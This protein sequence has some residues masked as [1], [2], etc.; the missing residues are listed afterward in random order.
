MFVGHIGAALALKTRAKDTSLASLFFAAMFIDFVW[1]L[2]ILLGIE[3][4]EIAPGYTAATPLKF[5]S[6]PY[7]HSLALVVLYALVIGVAYFLIKK[8]RAAAI[9]MAAAVLSHWLL[10]WVSHIPDL[11]LFPGSDIYAGLGLWKNLAASIEVEAAL[12]V[13]GI[14]LYARDFKFATKGRMCGFIALVIVLIA[15][16]LMPQFAPPPPSAKAVAVGALFM[17]L[18]VP[19][20]Y[21]VDKGNTRR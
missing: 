3:T 12:F 5:V 19:W 13:F 1:P 6:Y 18:F 4:V 11:P 8:N 7:S 2:L 15:L 16:W 9:V 17:W 20:A 21:W 14:F 10:D